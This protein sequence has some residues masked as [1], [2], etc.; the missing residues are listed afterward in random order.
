MVLV[1]TSLSEKDQEHGAISMYFSRH[2]V[3]NISRDWRTSC[4]RSIPRVA[5]FP[6][7]IIHTLGQLFAS[8]LAQI[9]VLFRAP[10]VDKMA[11]RRYWLEFSANDGESLPA[12]AALGCGVS[13][14]DCD[15]ALQIIRTTVFKGRALP[16]ISRKIPDVDVSALDPNHVRPNMGNVLRRGVWFPLGYE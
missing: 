6:G 9:R 8:S 4:P 12:G 16:E 1:L 2:P 13:A 5:L 14:Y 10:G 7:R 15:D 11:L 3:D